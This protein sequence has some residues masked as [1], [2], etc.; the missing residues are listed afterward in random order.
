[1]I[2]L[3]NLFPLFTTLLRLKRS[4]NM[5][6]MIFTLIIWYIPKETCWN[7]APENCT[8]HIH[9]PM[10]VLWM[11]INRN[12]NVLNSNSS[13]MFGFS[14]KKMIESNRKM[15]TE[16][17]INENKKKMYRWS[18]S[19]FG[20]HLPCGKCFA[21][22]SGNLISTPNFSPQA[23]EV[24]LRIS[25]FPQLSVK[26]KSSLYFRTDGCSSWVCY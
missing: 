1:M 19:F 25:L 3:W 14:V 26:L 21:T 10:V 15:A 24:L 23:F 13:W 2:K 7:R 5:C 12:S 22:L 20:K 11:P 17:N 6:V 4:N 18:L 16:R 8:K 9:M